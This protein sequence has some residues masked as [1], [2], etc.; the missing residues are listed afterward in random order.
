MGSLEQL[1]IRGL[2]TTLLGFEPLKHGVDPLAFFGLGHAG[3]KKHDGA[4]SL[5]IGRD[6]SPT[7]LA[8]TDLDD[9]L[10]PGYVGYLGCLGSLVCLMKR[11]RYGVEVSVLHGITW[12]GSSSHLVTVDGRT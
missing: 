6:R 11:E 10:G 2:A 9:R 1:L 5:A 12:C 3:R 4:V 8:A 7:P